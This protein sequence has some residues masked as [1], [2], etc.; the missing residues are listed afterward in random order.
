MESNL[1]YLFV[2]L[3]LFVAGSII[4]KMLKHGGFKG[5]IFGAGIQRT[6]AEVPGSGPGFGCLS[7]KAHKLDN[8]PRKSVGIELSSKSFSGYQMIPMTLS[9]TEV[10]QLTA[11]LDQAIGRK[12]ET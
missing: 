9:T 6:I 8:S 4:M 3:F 7:L 10:K 2:I 12:R 5:A 1:D 11:L